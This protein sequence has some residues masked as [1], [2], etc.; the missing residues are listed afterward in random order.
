[1][2]SNIF[3]NIAKNQAVLIVF[4]FLFIIF[5]AFV[6]AFFSSRNLINILKQTSILGIVACG[7]TFSVIAG[8]VD[9]SVGSI[10]SLCGVLALSFSYRNI[11]LAIFMPILV[12]IVI[13]LVNGLII[14][15]FN[16]N[17]VIITLGSLAVIRGLAL[18][19]TGG[20]MVE[21]ADNS[22][23]ILIGRSSIA[24]FPVYVFAFIA[25]AVI[26][27]II[28]NYTS[29]GRFVYHSG[30]NI[31]ASRIAGIKIDN[32]R[33]YTFIISAVCA[34]IAGII[35]SSRLYTAS[36]L[37]GNGYEFDAVAAIVVGG[38]SLFGGKGNI[39]RTVIGIFFI[40]MVINAMILLNLPVAFQY[41]AK[42]VIIIVAVWL[43]I[44]TSRV[45][46]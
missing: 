12:A 14:T 10:V 13:G 24:G 33:I 6:P 46:I 34:A 41:I 2:K 22:K 36:P 30:S 11:W 37:T 40:V 18:I 39:Y 1:M 17:S 21:G 25:I 20:K 32:I 31:D 43:D 23:F 28:I 29:L 15:K 7:L 4:I 38:N 8:N 27:G 35:L 9:L 44:R 45:N 3:K 26:L 19:Y 42:A 5:S 16:A